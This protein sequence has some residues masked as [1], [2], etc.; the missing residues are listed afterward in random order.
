MLEY[1]ALSLPGGQTVQPP[2]SI[3]QGG[4]EALSKAISGG[5]SIVMI[6]AVVLCLIAIARAGIQW[7]SSSGDKTKVAA[8]RSRITWA[9]IGL[10]VVFC[11]FILIN[12]LGGVF[13]VSLLQ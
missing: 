13:G 5:I 9:I 2:T 7:A 11:A 4:T 12:I 1:L 3:P 8:A 10:V 6:I